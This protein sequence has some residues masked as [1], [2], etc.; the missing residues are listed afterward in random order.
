MRFGVHV[1]INQGL[2]AA[3]ERAR[4]LRCEAVQMFSGN[5]NSWAK[6]PLDP[7]LA[8]AF[9]VGAKELTIHPII[10]HTPYLL[11]LAAPDDEIWEKSTNA[12]A[13]AVDRASKMDA[14]YVVT[15]IGSHKGAGYE[16]GVA[17]IARSVKA[18]LMAHPAPFI[19]LELGAGSGNTIGSCFEQIADILSGLGDAV[20]RVGICIDTAHLWGVGYD[21]SSA[22]GVD[23]MFEE[24]ER[25]AGADKLMVV[26]LNDT[27]MDLGSHRDRHY[28]IGQGQVGVDGFRAIV[29]HAVAR[30]VPGIVETPGHD[31]KS[32]GENLAVL[33]GLRIAD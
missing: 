3:L 17:R 1:R 32:D 14:R 22:R 33:R 4:E 24:M 7:G 8:A 12:L 30:N 15:H 20:A 19:A 16:A 29:N 21:I 26:H 2:I 18:A 6:K 10:L 27:Q 31:Y 23:A 28:H 25:Y 9:A 11:N 5:P 13:D